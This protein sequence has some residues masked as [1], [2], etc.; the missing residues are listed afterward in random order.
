MPRLPYHPPHCSGG[1]E[2]WEWSVVD[3][4]WPAGTEPAAKGDSGVVLLGREGGYAAGCPRTR[5]VGHVSSELPSRFSAAG[6]RARSSGVV[7]GCRSIVGSPRQS[8]LP[9]LSNL[10]WS[11]STTPDRRVVPWVPRVSQRRTSSVSSAGQYMYQTASLMALSLVPDPC[12]AFA[13]SRLPLEPNL[14]TS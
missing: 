2:G 7:G 10:F 9:S 6:G 8:Q 11:F 5:N 4:G 3:K 1:R 13:A 12:P 14:T